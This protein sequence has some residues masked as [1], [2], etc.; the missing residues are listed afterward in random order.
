MAFSIS[1]RRSG[2]CWINGLLGS[3]DSSRRLEK[4][5]AYRCFS[6]SNWISGSANQASSFSIEFWLNIW[7]Y[8]NRIWIYFL[9][10]GSVI[11]GLIPRIFSM[12]LSMLSSERE[13]IFPPIQ[14]TSGRVHTSESSPA[15][16][17]GPM[18]GILALISF[19]L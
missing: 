10:R 7:K 2:Y 9:I 1:S 17:A 15:W 14:N 19:V 3:K 18:R 13:R 12:F 5:R 16:S 11:F 4:F 6:L 8:L